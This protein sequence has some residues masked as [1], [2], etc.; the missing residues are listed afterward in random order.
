MHSGALNCLAQDV[1]RLQG[2][3][4]DLSAHH[5]TAMFVK[6][7][8]SACCSD[9]R[10]LVAGRLT[11][12]GLEPPLRMPCKRKENESGAGKLSPF[13]EE[14]LPATGPSPHRNDLGDDDADK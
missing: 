1:D 2:L 3:K 5:L 10:M 13:L 14:G 12:E 11:D 8:E 4:S 9:G 6:T 7:D